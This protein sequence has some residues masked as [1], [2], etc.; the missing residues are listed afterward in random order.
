M[1][2]AG[3]GI[4]QIVM[5][6]MVVRLYVALYGVNGSGGKLHEWDRIFRH[7]RNNFNQILTGIYEWMKVTSKK[8]DASPFQEL[9]IEDPENG[10]TK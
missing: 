3:I 9:F 6:Y 7:Q 4:V 8:V 1:V 2:V 5:F 10:R